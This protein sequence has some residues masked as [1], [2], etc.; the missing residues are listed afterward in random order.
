MKLGE[1]YF[2]ADREV[3]SAKSRSPKHLYSEALR[4]HEHHVGALLGLF[5][6]HRYN[7]HR[8]QR[9]ATDILNEAREAAPDSIPVLLAALRADLE[10]G[11]L[12][13]ARRGLKRLKSLAP[14]RRDVR[15]S[16]AT[17]YWIEHRRDECREILADLERVD[18]QDSKPFREVG[19]HLLSLYRFAE[20][21]EFLEHAVGIDPED[22][23][24]LQEY[25]RSLANTGREDEARGALAAAAKQARGRQ[26]AWRDNMIQVLDR[27]A[28]EL[29]TEQF[30]ELSFRWRPAAA[31]VMRT[32]LV[33]FYEDAREEF[34]GALR[35][36]FA[37][38]GDRS[39]RSS[40]RLFGAF[41]RLSGA[42]PRSECAL[43]R[44]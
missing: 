8:R 13:A 20:G 10:D 24:A 25:G 12:P 35:F 2:E 37:A 9:T 23:L 42:F 41:D 39:V 36:H 16:E 34:S 29:V 11:K 31:D 18:P 28:R 15:T 3:D 32:Y 21:Y 27:M 38:D 26:D 33:P 5:E 7:W 44:S 4:L 17:L 14:A 19:R 1:V 6:L 22:H 40:R 30:G 43:V